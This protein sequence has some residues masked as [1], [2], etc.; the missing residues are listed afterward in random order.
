[1]SMRAI[2]DQHDCHSRNST[3]FWSGRIFA[4]FFQ[5]NFSARITVCP[6]IT[7][8][9]ESMPRMFLM[10]PCTA[11]AIVIMYRSCEGSHVS[12]HDWYL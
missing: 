7:I 4:C 2:C 11:S 9:S 12:R 6:H 1:M 3:G 5:S 10:K 8:S